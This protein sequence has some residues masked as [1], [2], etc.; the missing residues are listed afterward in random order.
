MGRAGLAKEEERCNVPE[1]TYLYMYISPT[2]SCH[3]NS[4][5]ACL[6]LAFHM[7]FLAEMY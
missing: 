1:C 7:G 6:L 4:C 5:R 2:V 3:A